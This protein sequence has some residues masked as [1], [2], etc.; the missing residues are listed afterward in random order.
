MLQ[1]LPIAIGL[2][3]LA[4]IIADWREQ[5]PPL[6]KLLK[7]LTTLLIIA[8]CALAASSGYRNA[9][10]AALLLSLIGDVALMYESDR[11]FI[12]GLVSFLLA[13]LL[14]MLAF[15]HGVSGATMPAAGWGFAV[16]ALIFAGLLLP[17]APGALRL[18]VLIY[19]LVLC[20]MAV[21]ALIRW[22][23]LDGDSGHYALL[24]AMLFLISDSALGIRKFF[25]PYGGAQGLILST[26]WGAIALIAWSAHGV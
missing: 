22:Q 5:R 15:L 8:L 10:L 20:A 19:G 1:L 21:T 23:T 14:F 2:S 17:R 13:H 11:A 18:P 16:Y 12:T 26:Y 9:L 4:A 24:G 25:G 7:P 3:A 6:F